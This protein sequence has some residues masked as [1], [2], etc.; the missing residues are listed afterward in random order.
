M[1]TPT[2]QTE[3]RSLLAVS[4]SIAAKS[5]IL[6][7]PRFFRKSTL[8]VRQTVAEVLGISCKDKEKRRKHEIFGRL[9]VG[10]M[11]CRFNVFGQKNCFSL[12]SSLFLITFAEKN[13]L[14]K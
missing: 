12:L 13:N 9:F 11:H 4:K 7:S 6:I 10:S 3:L 1:T 5:N 8:K 14:V 2:E